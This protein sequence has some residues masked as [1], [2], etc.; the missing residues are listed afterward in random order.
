[1]KTKY[2][3][4]QT[5]YVVDF[6]KQFLEEVECIYRGDMEV[7][8]IEIDIKGAIYYICQMQG[9]DPSTE[10][11]REEHVF[12]TEKQAIKFAERFNG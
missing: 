5:V 2:D 3:I 12:K 6:Y 1:M 11:Y 4:K 7:I 9:D 10:M 8:G